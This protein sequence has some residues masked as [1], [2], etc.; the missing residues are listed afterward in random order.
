MITVEE[1]KGLETTVDVVE[2]KTYWWCRCGRSKKQPFC[3]GS[4]KGHGFEP[5]IW[6]AP[7]SRVMYFCTCKRT[8]SKP[9][10][11]GSH[12]ELES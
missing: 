1:G 2:G 6:K 3:D 5:M 8:D 11:D 12:K 9:F 10:C 4:H 7:F